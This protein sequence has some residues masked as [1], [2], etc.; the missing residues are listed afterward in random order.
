[1]NRHQ[2]DEKLRQRHRKAA[3]ARR[4]LDG[5]RHAGRPAPGN[6]AVGGPGRWGL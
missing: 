3:G 6:G 1:M 2:I 4:G 5:A